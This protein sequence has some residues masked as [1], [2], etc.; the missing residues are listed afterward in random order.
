MTVQELHAYMEGIEVVLQ[1]DLPTY[2]QWKAIKE[3]ISQLRQSTITTHYEPIK[4][5]NT[6]FCQDK[7]DEL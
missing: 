2:K 3:K 6:V 5:G 1:G 4:I 7:N